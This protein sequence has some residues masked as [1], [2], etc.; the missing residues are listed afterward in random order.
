M[1]AAVLLTAGTDTT[2]N[3]LAA[4]VQ[5]LCE[6]PAQ[7]ALLAQ[8]PELAPQAVEE[9]MRHSPVVF[10]ALRT[11]IEDVE[12]GGVIIPAGTLVIANTGAANRDPAVYDDPDRLD[13]TR[14]DPP[15]MLTFGG[16]AH[17]CLG[18]HVARLELAEALTVITRRM[19]NAHRTGPAPWKPPSGMSGPTTLPI[20]FDTGH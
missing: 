16:G 20:E 17:Y 10:G 3:Q 18:A 9:T 14:D 8:H 5:V 11:A 15:A 6:H 2:R 12:L 13:I 7:W 19:P 1:L 4:A